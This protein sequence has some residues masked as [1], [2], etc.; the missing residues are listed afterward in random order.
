M[1]A[2]EK[3]DFELVM[4]WIE[5]LAFAKEICKASRVVSLGRTELRE[6]VAFLHFD[7]VVGGQ[8]HPEQRFRESFA[9]LRIV[10]DSALTPEMWHQPMVAVVQRLMAEVPAFGG[11][12]Y[13]EVPNG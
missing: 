7:R 9:L 10:V 12:F 13:S 4:L 3:L 11:R 5:V 8:N 6:D 2:T 1:A